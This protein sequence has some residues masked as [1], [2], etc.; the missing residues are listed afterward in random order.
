M[1]KEH[2]QKIDLYY[3]FTKDELESVSDIFLEAYCRK[4]GSAPE[5]CEIETNI[6]VERL[7]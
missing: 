2:L 4:H 3:L 6:I 1:D 5:V 7:R